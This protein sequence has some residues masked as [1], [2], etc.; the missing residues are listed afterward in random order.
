MG[1]Q[2]G[3]LTNVKMKRLISGQIKCEYKQIGKWTN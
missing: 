1:K 2:I 3:R